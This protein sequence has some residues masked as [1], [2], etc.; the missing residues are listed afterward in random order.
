MRTYD[1]LYIGGEWVAPHSARAIS[2]IDP[3]TEDVWA[4]VAEADEQDVDKAVAA[5]RA[6]MD[7]PW[8]KKITASGRGALLYKLAELV[9]RDAARLAEL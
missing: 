7:G 5:A 6:A 2:S 9:K 1:R 4:E 3:S 8:R